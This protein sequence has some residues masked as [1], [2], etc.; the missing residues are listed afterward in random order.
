M[1]TVNPVASGA[2][3]LG[4]LRCAVTGAA[5]MGLFYVLCWAG[6][7]L[8]LTNVSHMYLALFTTA[9]MMS[10]AALFIGVGW[11]LAFG[12]VMGGLSAAIYNGLGFLKPR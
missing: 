1:T 10:P 5:V 7:A 8:N 12:A 6:A 11:S 4:V 2:G 9:P 3:Q